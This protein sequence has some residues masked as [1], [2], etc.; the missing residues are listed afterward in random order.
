[1]IDQVIGPGSQGSS[2]I[3]IRRTYDSKSINTKSRRREPAP[4]MEQTAAYIN[5]WAATLSFLVIWSQTQI[6]PLRWCVSI[7][8]LGACRVQSGKSTQLLRGYSYF[9][10]WNEPQSCGKRHSP[11]NNS[12]IILFFNLK[13]V[14]ICAQSA[15]CM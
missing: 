6:E 3:F 5:T 1:M 4:L 15:S 8:G 10:A 13:R 12:R 9:C 11:L 2:A 7:R 14:N